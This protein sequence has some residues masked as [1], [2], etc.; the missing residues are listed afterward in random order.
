VILVAS[1]ALIALADPRD[2]LNATAV[3]DLKRLRARDLLLVSPVVT[4]VC[5]AL[6]EAYQRHR[7]RDLIRELR[8]RPL[9]IAGEAQ[10]WNEVFEWLTRYA[11]H[12][13][14]WADGYLAVVCG[15]DKRLRVWSYDRE[16]RSVWRRPDGTRIPLAVKPVQ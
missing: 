15:R 10:L 16:F 7:V 3:A 14:D 13:P 1:N 4:E 9:V 5:F 12:E 11:E 8:I 6:P 2:H